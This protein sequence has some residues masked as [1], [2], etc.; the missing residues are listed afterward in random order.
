MSDFSHN[1][2]LTAGEMQQ[3]NWYWTPKEGRFVAS[4]NYTDT[5]GTEWAVVYLDGDQ[6]MQ[7]TMMLKLTT[8]V[9]EATPKV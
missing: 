5:D 6:D 9:W 8:P 2:K 3:G 1:K 7:S 4:R